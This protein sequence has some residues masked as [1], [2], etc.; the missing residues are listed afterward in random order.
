MRPWSSSTK[1]EPVARPTWMVTV[2]GRA[3]AATATLSIGPAG[4]ALGVVAAGVGAE[5]LRSEA[6][7]AVGAAVTTPSR[8]ASRAPP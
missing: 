2:P 1:P 8:P 5:D 4:S 6:A 7:G 3:R